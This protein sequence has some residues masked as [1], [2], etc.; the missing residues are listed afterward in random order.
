M[1]S[2]LIIG[3]LIVLSAGLIIYALWPNKGTEEDVLKRRLRGQRGVDEIAQINKKAKESAAQKM[4]ERMAPIAMKP[5]MPT[6]ANE[7]SMLR[8]KLNNAGF[9]RENAPM[10]FLA[11]KTVLGMAAAGL[12]LLWAMMSGKN[13]SQMMTWLVMAG[14]VAFLLPNFWLSQAITKRAQRVQRGLADAMDL[15]VIA[16]ESGL[17]LDAALQRVAEEMANVHPDLSEELAIVTYEGQ[18]GIPR[19]EALNNL[20]ARTGVAEVKSLVGV[21]TQAERFGT[22]IAKALRNQANAMRL[23][24]R[25]KAEEKAQQTAVKLL[26]PLIFFIFPALFV[27]L[28]GPAAMDMIEAFKRMSL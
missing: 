14:G 16:V 6:N 8:I 17:A 1:N 24:R 23:K 3:V 5:V 7:L 10:L 26:L 22:S 15:M 28:V 21:I 27:V 25:Q 18:M 20:A 4:F 12:G 11:S 13:M 2:L 19:S 9:R